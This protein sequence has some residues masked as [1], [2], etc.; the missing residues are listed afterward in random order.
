MYTNIVKK[1]LREDI[2]WAIRHVW[3]V[4]IKL[5]LKLL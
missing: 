3:E 2:T 1:T 5:E 4:T